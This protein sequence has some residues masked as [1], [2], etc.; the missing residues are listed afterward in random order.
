M[1]TAAGPIEAGQVVLAAGAWL[2]RLLRGSGIAAPLVH[3]H[4]EV[5]ESEPLPPT[6]QHLIASA[7][8]S[9]AVLEAE[10]ARP[11]NAAR[12]QAEA[13]GEEMAPVSVELGVVQRGDGRVRLG[14][15]SR[16]V[17]GILDGPRPDGE[18]LIRAEVA[19]YFP[20]LARQPVRHHS[21]P[22]S[23]SPD[24]LPVAGPIAA[25]PGFWLVSAL[26]S[27][28]IYL[29]ALAARMT[30]ALKGE[31]VPELDAFALERF[32]AP[33]PPRPLAGEGAGG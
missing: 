27:P 10:I 28:L 20:D 18:A 31:R 32:P 6:F 29:P 2:G 16:A 26:N 33:A 30:G 17:A 11:A 22:V 9:R 21:R 8:Q 7:N 19:L 3:T 4:A 1:E 12:L 23:F 14:Q 5:L 13:G 24:K 25:A 15:L